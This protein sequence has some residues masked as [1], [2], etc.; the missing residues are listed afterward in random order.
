MRVAAG[1]M[2][3]CA[4]L[5]LCILVING[6]RFISEPAMPPALLTLSVTQSDAWRCA[7]ALQ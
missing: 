2:F 7:P 4:A 1:D 3:M 6:Y 5:L